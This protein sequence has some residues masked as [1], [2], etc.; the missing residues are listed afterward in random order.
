MIFSVTYNIDLYSAIV[1]IYFYVIFYQVK[2]LMFYNI[3]TINLIFFRK[4]WDIQ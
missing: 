3:Q 2:F 1:S 4:V